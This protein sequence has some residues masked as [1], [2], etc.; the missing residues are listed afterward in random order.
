MG[1]FDFLNFGEIDII[2]AIE[3]KD[4]RGILKSLKS[5]DPIVRQQAAHAMIT[6]GDEAD[7]RHLVDALNDS[8]DDVRKWAACAL[9]QIK[10]RKA[11]PALIKALKGPGF[12]TPGFA[13]EALGKLND[14]SA[15]DALVEI[16]ENEER[17][18]FIRLRAAEA[19]AK[20][21]SDLAISA[22]KKILTYENDQWAEELLVEIDN[23]SRIEVDV[24][25]LI[26]E[27]KWQKLVEIGK[28]T[29]IHLIQ[30]LLGGRDY[31]KGKAAETLGQIGDPRAAEPLVY[32]LTKVSTSKFT[33]QEFKVINAITEIG[34][35][36]VEF[37]IMALDTDEEHVVEN[38]ARTLGMIG[39][40]RGIIPLVKSLNRSYYKKTYKDERVFALEK[41]GGPALETMQKLL[42]HENLNLR[43]EIAESLGKIGNRETIPH[44]QVALKNS[45]SEIK[46]TINKAIRRIQLKG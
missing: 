30:V 5:K 37:L 19:L 43:E 7:M 35:P 28:P 32:T 11:L 23:T 9:G 8:E 24:E 34:H 36:A 20:I 33:F 21:K 22:L 17:D 15:V 18:L 31:L 3:N 14:P 38:V 25:K 39:S 41:I 44:L 10:C 40:T 26:S 29:V 46:D 12:Y 16:L 2:D 4:K 42:S 27:E 45:P 6:M 1:I 13:A